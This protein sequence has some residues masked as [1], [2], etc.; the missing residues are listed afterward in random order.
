[1][2][3]L[4]LV[5]C[6]GFCAWAYGA[7]DDTVDWL[8]SKHATTA[9]ATRPGQ[10]TT[11]ATS[12]FTPD[13]QRPVRRAT[14]L[15]SDGEKIRA[16][17]ATTRDKPIRVWIEQDK[18]YRDVPFD[19]IQSM[20]ASVLWERDEKEWAFKESGSDI[21]VYSGKTYPARELQ[22]TLTL[23][24]GQT[25]TGGVVAPIYVPT[26]EG[27]KVYV[28]HKR[29]KGEVGQTLGQLVYVKSVQFE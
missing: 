27:D 23:L 20:Q 13:P 7:G 9:P 3:Y 6:G 4:A 28:L 14:L 26:R 10:P 22:Y 24:N 15:L 16:A 18:E 12:P 5:L 2:R 21:K 8:L 29:Q 25:I 19:L 17:I 11:S 1:M